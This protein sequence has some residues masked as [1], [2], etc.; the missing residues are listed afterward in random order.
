MAN[1]DRHE[2]L[3]EAVQAARSKFEERQDSVQNAKDEYYEAVRRLHEAGMPLRDVAAKLGLSH[4]RV[5]QMIA[6]STG[7]KRSGLARAKKAAGPA[8]A[9]LLALLLA[10]SAWLWSGSSGDDP[11]PAATRTERVAESPTG[12]KGDKGV[13]FTIEGPGL[14]FVE[15]PQVWAKVRGIEYKFR[16]LDTVCREHGGNIVCDASIGSRLQW[17]VR[18]TVGSGKGL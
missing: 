15:G 3:L 4:Q 6:E 18:K 13:D 2:R 11:E 9:V 8:G 5:H 7:E 16:P 1:D 12:H 17:L 10:G 14:R